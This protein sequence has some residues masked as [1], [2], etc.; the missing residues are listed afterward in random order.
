MEGELLDVIERI[1]IS[2]VAGVFVPIDGLESGVEAGGTIGF[3]RAG[4]TDVPVLSPFGGR[5]M[6]VVA[7]AGER[8][9]AYQRIAWMRAA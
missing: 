7:S 5:I 6:A 4:G 2:P 3:V 1:V 8:L 9:I